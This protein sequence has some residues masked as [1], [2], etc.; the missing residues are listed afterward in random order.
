MDTVNLQ[1]V[2]RVFET[3]KR[4]FLEAPGTA[5]ATS[6]S[7]QLRS[8]TGAEARLTLMLTWAMSNNTTFLR[9]NDIQAYNLD[10]DLPTQVLVSQKISVR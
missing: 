3:C 2:Q 6:C 1:R 8:E 7:W 5:T 4:P 9:D 10:D